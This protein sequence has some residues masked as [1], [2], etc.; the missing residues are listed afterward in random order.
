MDFV[1]SDELILKELIRLCL[2]YRSK[3]G[4]AT[5]RTTVVKSLYDLKRSLPENNSIR[6]KLPYYWFKAGA[7]SEYV[8]AALDDMV[9]ENIV[10]KITKSDYELYKLN[11]E[12]SGRRLN[13]HDSNL[14]EAREKLST[15][16]SNMRPFSI[17]DE[18]KSQYQDDA[19]SKFYPQFKLEFLRNLELYSKRIEPEI[20]QKKN[21]QSAEQREH[22]LELLRESTASL[23]Y[24]SLFSNFK[25]SYFDFETS[26]SRILKMNVK[27]NNPEYLQLIKESIDLSN[28]IWDTFAYGARIIKHDPA[29]DNRIE[30]WKDTFE[31]EA[32]YLAAEVNVFY[33]HA[34]K[35]TKPRD[36]DEI[37]L[38]LS[39]FI[40][41]IIETRKKQEII[42]INF[43]TIPDEEYVSKTLD[44][45]VK[46]IQ[47]WGT[48]LREGQLD[49]TIIKELTDKQLSDI[50]NHCTRTGT[51][52]VA[53][54][55]KGIGP[56]T[57]TF[58]IET[59]SLSFVMQTGIL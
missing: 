19:P 35:T 10:F 4:L 24:D 15:I 47:E 28:K 18:I 59:N 38:S 21:K 17:D 23:P 45:K 53:F 13:P 41:N 42:F 44:E 12:Y 7:Y 26:F 6:E 39:E 51:I 49:W 14:I 32:D 56:K 54:S 36:F 46:Q 55:E 43:Q 1:P 8:V 5:T 22:L 2:L 11:P 58:R 9:A 57:R 20:V 52:Y 40:Q 29:Y 25:K 37:T 48:F 34:L 33:E 50:I 31:K 27:D 3:K 16:I 30:E